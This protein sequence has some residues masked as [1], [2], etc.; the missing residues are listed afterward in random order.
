MVKHEIP[1]SEADGL[2]KFIHHIGGLTLF[3]P[4]TVSTEYM[5]TLDQAEKFYRENVPILKWLNKKK[6]AVDD[7]TLITKKKMS[8]KT[9]LDM[10]GKK[11]YAYETDVA[12]KSSGT[13]F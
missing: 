11:N 7:N 4:E 6:T 10:N 3:Y 8:S 13:M 12:F 5:T 9:D 1:L 2:W